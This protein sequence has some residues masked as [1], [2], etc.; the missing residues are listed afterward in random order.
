MKKKNNEKK[1]WVK[2]LMAQQSGNEKEW[3]FEKRTISKVEKK[4]EQENEGVNKIIR[5]HQEI[6]QI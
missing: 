1:K 4:N 6:T 2:S 3:K 5:N